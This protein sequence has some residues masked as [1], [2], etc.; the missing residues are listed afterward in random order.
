MRNFAEEMTILV[1]IGALG[2]LTV[3]PI[4]WSLA[5]LEMALMAV[6]PIWMML[7]VCPHCTVQGSDACPSGF[8]VVSERLVERR[9]PKLFAQAFAHNIYGALPMW[10]VPIAG[11]VYMLYAGVDVPLLPFIG[12]LVMAFA[13]TPIRAKYFHCKRCPRR[14]ECPW[15]VKALGPVQ[16][17]SNNNRAPAR[18]LDA[19][20]NAAAQGPMETE[21]VANMG[22]QR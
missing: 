20:G 14:G 16:G 8:G 5:V 17:M 9:D 12:F 3:L 15:G 4:H 21:P 10:F 7:T 18:P 6:S 22:A 13:V 19:P 2:A 1:L 11:V